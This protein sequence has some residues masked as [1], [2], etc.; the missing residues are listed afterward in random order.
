MLE[1]EW[2]AKEGWKTPKI[3]PF[4]DLILSPATVVL[5][6]SMEVNK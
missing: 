3:S 1:V 5:Q 6:Y 2:T 4:H